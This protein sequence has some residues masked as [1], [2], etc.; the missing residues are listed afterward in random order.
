MS[1]LTLDEEEYLKLLRKYIHYD[2]T[3]WGRKTYL[4]IP[5]PVRLPTNDHYLGIG[6]PDV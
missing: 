6:F 2:D 5:D 3:F 1:M 4:V